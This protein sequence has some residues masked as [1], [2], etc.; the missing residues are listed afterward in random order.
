MKK[1][2]LTALIFIL[3]AGNH[4]YA[5]KYYVLVAPDDSFLIYPATS[6]YISTKKEKQNYKIKIVDLTEQELR[7]LLAPDVDIEAPEKPAS[8]PL[9]E[10]DGAI[11]V[12]VY[13]DRKKKIVY[14]QLTKDLEEISQNEL[15]SKTSVKARPRDPIYIDGDNE[16]KR[17]DG[18]HRIG[19]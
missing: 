10:Y 3:S 18:I 8:V 15:D 19:Q 9:E 2:F 14:S 1:I 16:S 5:D 17:D 11:T 6:Q 13:S 7:D 12:R 4:C